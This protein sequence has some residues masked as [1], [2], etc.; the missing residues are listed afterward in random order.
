VRREPGPLVSRLI[1]LMNDD[2]LLA[3]LGERITSL[4][5][6]LIDIRRDLHAHPELSR[7][8]TRTT[9][10]MARRLDASGVGVRLLPGTG[11]LADI[12]DPDAP[13]R[14][15]LRADMDALPVRERTGLD[16]ASRE[17]GV[18]HACGHDVHVAALLGALLA[19][20]E[21]E[22]AL[23]ERGIAVRGIFQAAEEIMPGGAHDAITA[24]ALDLVDAVFAVHCDPSLDTGEVGLREG[25]LTAACDQLTVSLHGRGGHTSRPQLTE[26]L[27][28]ALAKVV[29]DVPAALS[30]RLDPRAGAALVWGTI[31]AGRAPNVIP[32]T[33]ECRGTLRMLDA[34]AWLTVGP[35][36]EE[37]VHA[38]VEPYGVQAKVERVKGV[39]PV[40]NT[41]EGI[42]LFRLATLASG[43]HPV[44]TTQSLGG[45]DFSWYLAHA[46][47][48]MA[49]LGTRVHG[50]PTFDL[51]QGDLI[52]DED[53]ILLGARLLASVAVL[54][55]TGAG[56]RPHA[57]Q[58]T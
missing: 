9:E 29:T 55:R 53:A 42:E 31:N 44:P 2:A 54:R 34:H 37:I 28:Y 57:M 58:A 25:P 33:G 26:D 21:C 17:A 6:E 32:S 52:V 18:C 36:L 41:A 27:T 16:F 24:G 38:V 43:M 35:L 48:A 10:R 3:A 8:E 45:E 19:L 11:L 39:P 20:K 47:G 13:Y 30:R 15:A 49:R 46:T 56:H 14:V 22:P 7:E 5:A 51:H 12:G 40:V 1:R 4:A 23:V 50:G